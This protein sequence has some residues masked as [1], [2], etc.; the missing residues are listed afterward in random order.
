M[1]RYE[2][3]LVWKQYSISKLKSYEVERKHKSEVPLEIVEQLLFTFNDLGES[4]NESC[5]SL[6]QLLQLTSD[7]GAQ[8]SDRGNVVI[9]FVILASEEQRSDLMKDDLA[10]V[11]K[12]F[13]IG[14][15][16]HYLTLVQVV[17]VDDLDGNVNSLSGLLELHAH[18]VNAI[19]DAFAA[20]IQKKVIRTHNIFLRTRHSPSCKPVVTVNIK[21]A[22]TTYEFS[23]KTYI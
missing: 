5:V 16:W 9:N 21:V 18:F 22:Y 17:L 6:A 2:F 4:G 15:T 19:D 12:F 11:H 20:L 8:V 10:R 23:Q 13:L 7:V 1:V 3:Q 14:D